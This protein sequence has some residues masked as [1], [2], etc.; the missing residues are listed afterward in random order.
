MLA[1]T[2]P[3]VNNRITGINDLARAP[4]FFR[5]NLLL[6]LVLRTDRNRKVL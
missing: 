6:D 5:V 3:E 4:I 2:T 1:L